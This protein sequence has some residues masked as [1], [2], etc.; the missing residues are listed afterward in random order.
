[1]S[2]AAKKAAAAPKKATAKK[3][4]IK[5]APA[6]K[7]RPEPNLTA[8]VGSTIEIEVD[9]DAGEVAIERPDGSEVTVYAAGGRAL[10][11]LDQ[12]GVHVA[13]GLVVDATDGDK[14]ED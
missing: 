14:G 2:R 11:V 12:I 4:T 7:P 3:A 5:E 6:A 10:Y 8:P 9:V 13:G 1:M